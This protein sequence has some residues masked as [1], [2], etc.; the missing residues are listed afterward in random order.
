MIRVENA[1]PA[2]EKQI[3]QV[4]AGL[5][6]YL[7]RGARI[8]QIIIS[9]QPEESGE[10][11]QYEHGT[12]NLYLMPNLRGLEL[13]RSLVHEVAHAIDD[14]FGPGHYWGESP[15]WIMLHRSLG[16]PEEHSVETFAELMMEYLLNPL[17]LRRSL[18]RIAA[19]MAGALR[20]LEQQFR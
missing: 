7:V 11:A 12:R 20:Y 6:Y 18:P 19:F 3:A 5:P 10:R 4:V 13:R 1:S 8:A 17:G 14:N 16:R 15:H 2:Y 9:R